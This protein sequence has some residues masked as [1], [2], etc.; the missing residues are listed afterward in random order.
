MSR[1]IFDRVVEFP[2]FFNIACGHHFGEPLLHPD[3]LYIAE[4]CREKG[5]FFGFSTNAELLTMD[6]LDD[7]VKAGLSW[8][9]IS[10]HTERAERIYREIID[11][12]P[13]LPVLTSEL[14]YIH[15]W[16]G[17]VDVSRVH[18]K[19][20]Y[21]SSEDSGSGDCIFHVEDLCVIDSEG[22]ILACCMDA[23]GVSTM[24][25]IT[26]MTEVEFMNM[27]NN[28]YFHLCRRCH[29]KAAEIKGEY[30]LFETLAKKA[31]DFLMQP[32]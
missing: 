18:S 8:I 15:D 10:F 9:K 14:D 23:H 13:M 22:R 29:I 1:E 2:F 19:H 12:Y 7:L 16:A 25:T 26:D 20:I 5:L 28:L 30:N 21:S 4:R 3:L 24:A 17:Q 11:R 27:K 6:I 32:R 31:E